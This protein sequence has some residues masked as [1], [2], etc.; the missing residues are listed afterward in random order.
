MKTVKLFFNRWF[1]LEATKAT[2]VPRTIEKKVFSEFNSIIKQNMSHN[3]LLLYI[4]VT[5]SILIGLK[6]AANSCFLCFS[7]VIPTDN[8]LR[9]RQIDLDNYRYHAQ[10]HPIIREFKKRRRLRLRQRHKTIISLV[11]RA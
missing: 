5:S 2:L 9:L 4:G 10:P 1:L 8:N 7:Y 6:Y 11:K 3:L